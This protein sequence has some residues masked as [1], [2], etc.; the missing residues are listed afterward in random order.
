MRKTSMNEDIKKYPIFYY[1]KGK[2]LKADDIFSTNDYNHSTHNLH[3]YIPKQH[4]DKNKSWYEERGI[5]QKLILM[6]ISMHEQVHNQAIHN[7]S[8]DDFYGWYKIDRWE[9]VF[10]RRHSKY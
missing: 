5:K 6:P 7:L 10:N 9:L 4:Y 1:R 3:H 8:D 2:L